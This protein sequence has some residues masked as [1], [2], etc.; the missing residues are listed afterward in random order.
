[1]LSP[2][3][4][5]RYY[6][7]RWRRLEK[8]VIIVSR[9]TPYSMRGVKVMFRVDRRLTT[10]MLLPLAATTVAAQ[11]SIS[12]VVRDSITRAPLRL[13]IVQL[14]HA[15]SMSG[16]SAITDSLGRFTIEAVSP[17]RYRIGF[18]HPMLD[19]LGLDPI[20]RAVTV[21]DAA[22][23][24]VDLAIPSAATLRRAMCPR[25]RGKAVIAGFVRDAHDHSP[26]ASAMVAAD[27]LELTFQKGGIVRV[28]PRSDAITAANGWFALC[29][30]PSDGIMGLFAARRGD[31]TDVL[32]VHVPA[33]GFLRHDLYLGS[34]RTA[35]L[36]GTVVSAVTGQPIP[37]AQIS[38]AGVPPIRADERGNW[39][40][41]G[42]PLG[43]RSIEV[44]A[45]GFYP[46][47]GGVNVTVDAPAV[48]TRLSS[49]R[50]VLDTVRILAARLQ[51][52]RESGFDERRRQGGGYYLNAQQI[53]Q[54]GAHTATD[55]FRGLRGVRIGFASDTMLSDNM[56]LVDPDSLKTTNHRILMRGITG[57]LCAPSIFLNGIFVARMD[58]DDLDTW[59][60]P[61]EISGIE[62]Y[63]EATAPAQFQRIGKGCGSIIIWTRR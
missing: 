16:R 6:G 11:A 52:R 56:A 55:L 8:A 13:A 1:M 4:G 43:T 10:L 34:G 50:A 5:V 54:K 18:L 24:S 61:K 32:D 9:R 26:V 44:R 57:D 53:A 27:W 41:N 14:V 21:A 39:A 46:E 22:P 7:R 40:V 15:D 2:P 47:R 37:S 25:S 45:V 17:A 29:D 28:M 51:D 59:A 63:T 19:S 58:A 36:T 31:S 35:R 60:T 42:L 48:H 20:V 49:L 62:I 23:L 38:I 3:K 30:V 33:D 12:G